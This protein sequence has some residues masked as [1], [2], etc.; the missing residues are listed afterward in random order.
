MDDSSYRRNFDLGKKNEIHH[1]SYTFVLRAEVCTTF[2]SKVGQI[3][4]RIIQE[5][6]KFAKFA[7]LYFPHFTTFRDQSLQFH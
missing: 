7:G 4:A 5:H 6:T 1:H 3:S 2:G